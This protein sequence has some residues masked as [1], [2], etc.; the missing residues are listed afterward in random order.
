[1]RNKIILHI[2]SKWVQIFLWTRFFEIL[3]ILFYGLNFYTE[4]Y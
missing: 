4:Y 1:M 3:K 2:F